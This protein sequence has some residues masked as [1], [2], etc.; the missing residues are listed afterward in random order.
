MYKQGQTQVFSKVVCVADKVNSGQLEIE[1]LQKF[2]G[3]MKFI[4]VISKV[5]WINKK[6]ADFRF[7]GPKSVPVLT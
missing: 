2:E 3:E 5:K 1:T 4:K 7:D 6:S